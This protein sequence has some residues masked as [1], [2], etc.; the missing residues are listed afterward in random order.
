MLVA[1]NYTQRRHRSLSVGIEQP[2]DILF[3]LKQ[4]IET[5]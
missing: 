5:G 1:A 4:C 2:D 3:Y